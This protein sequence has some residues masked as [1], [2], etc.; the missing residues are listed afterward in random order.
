MLKLCVI[1]DPVGHSLS[2]TLHT[3]MLEKAGIA[4]QYEAVTVKTGELAAFVQRAKDGAY[5]G[6][7]VTMPHK[8]SIIPLLD[9]LAPSAQEMGAVNTVVVRQERAIGYNTDGDGLVRSLP[10]LP[11]KAVVLGNGGAAKA[12]SRALRQSGVEVVICARHPV[13]E[14]V[15]WCEIENTVADCELLVNATCLG[16]TGKEQFAD[17]EFLKCLPENAV[18][19]DLVYEPR[20]T[21]LLQEAEILC[22]PIVEGLALLKSQAEL[23]FTIFTT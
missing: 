20:K 8:E 4:G 7:N 10:Q 13:G 6:F 19:Y 17:F 2:P 11:R 16:M 21:K 15:P 12:V 1:G 9:E 23:A 5:D 14:Q 3:E 18:V 22:H